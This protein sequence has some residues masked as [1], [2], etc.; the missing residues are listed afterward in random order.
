MSSLEA[1][2]ETKTWVREIYRGSALRYGV[3]EA[4]QGRVIIAWQR[5]ALIW[6]LAF[7]SSDRRL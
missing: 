7:V 5:C 4:G 2:A 6:R 1:E 3:V